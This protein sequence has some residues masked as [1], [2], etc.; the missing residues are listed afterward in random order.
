MT[1]SKSPG[2]INWLT[3]GLLGLIWGASFMSTAVALQGAGP[4][5]VSAIRLAI[6]ALV[7]FAVA[8]AMGHRLPPRSDRKLWLCIIGMGV[9]S[10]AVPFTLLGLAIQ[11]VPSAFAGVTMAAVPLLV[12]PLAHFLV[13]GE[14]MSWIKC[15]GFAIG[16]VGVFILIG[17]LSIFEAGGDTLPKLACIGAA[18]CYAIGSIITRLAPPAHP[19]A[20][21]TGGLVIG[22]LIMVPLALMFEGLPGAMPANAIAALL[23][24]ALLP[25][26]LATILLVRVIQSAGPS[27]MSLV[28]YQ[29]P[30]WSVLFGVAL[31]SEALPASFLLA[32]GLILGGLALTQ[33]AQKRLGR[34]PSA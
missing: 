11:Y 27:F 13:P 10:N 23:Y 9:F 33:A 7:L 30:V 17:G 29:V 12:L 32:L 1:S 28:N 15:A 3:L 14:R 21:S 31:M 20:F 18:F 34:Y 8:R 5:S 4:L 16:F 19:I 26:A 22:A 6:G 24:L 25:T 2:L